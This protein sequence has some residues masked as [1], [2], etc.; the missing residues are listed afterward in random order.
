[1]FRRILIT[2]ALLAGLAFSSSAAWAGE[3]GGSEHGGA[4]PAA[5]SSSGGGAVTSADL[6]ALKDASQALSGTNPSLAQKL[7]SLYRKLGGK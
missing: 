4:A 6:R 5:S 7:D 2:A 3:H 1:M